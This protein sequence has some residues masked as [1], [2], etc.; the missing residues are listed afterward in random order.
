MEKI[1]KWNEIKDNF[2]HTI[3]LGNGASIAIDRCFAY[4]SLYEEASKAVLL[5]AE[6]QQLFTH[7]KTTDFEFIMQLLWRTH[8][9]NNLLGVHDEA[10][11]A[12]YSSVR[13]S[14]IKTVQRVH[15]SYGAA[16]PHI[17]AIGAFLRSFK[18]VVSLN[19]DLLVYWA[20]LHTNKSQGGPVFKD[21]FIHE[22]RT[23]E[24]DV[25][26]LRKPYGKANS[27]TLVFYPHGNLILATNY[28][29]QET[30]ICSDQNADLLETIVKRWSVSDSTPLFVSE[31]ESAQKLQSINRNSYL[32]TVYT[33]II[34]ELDDGS[35]IC[36]YGWSMSEQDDHLLK[37]IGKNKPRF[38]AVSVYMQ[39]EKWPE[40]CEYVRGQLEKTYGFKFCTVLFF[41]SQSAGCWIH[42]PK[43]D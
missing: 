6:L 15:V 13:D 20:M 4:A 17:P 7:Y 41:D 10:V 9:I 5:N 19:Y 39:S 18:N 16:A 12:A 2:K 3:I 35:A 32:H 21:C 24:E 23:F 37:A 38:L 14:L 11:A 25:E 29:G 36:V 42:P 40:F 33:D 34:Q 26:W 28:Q 31:G 30:K 22:D 8:Q 1:Y 43:T 27:S